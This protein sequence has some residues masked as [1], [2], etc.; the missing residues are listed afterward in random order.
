[1]RN[2]DDGL[3]TGQGTGSTLVAV[4]ESGQG[5]SGEIALGVR[6]A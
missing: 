4:T 1:V 5:Y 6:R 2:A 3:F